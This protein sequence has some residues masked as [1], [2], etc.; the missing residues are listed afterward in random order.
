MNHSLMKKI[1]L[2]ALL[3]FVLGLIGSTI[4]GFTMYQNF[5]G[6]DNELVLRKSVEY[7]DVD[8]LK[9]DL[10]LGVGQVFVSGG[11]EQLMEGHFVYSERAGDPKLSYQQ[12]NGTGHVKLA[13][14][15]RTMP[16]SFFNFGEFK[17][18]WQVKLNKELPMNLSISTGVGEAELDLRGV[19]L[20]YL[21]IET[22]VGKTMID[23]SG[24]WQESFRMELETGV[25]QTVL[26]LPEEVGVKVKAEL[27]LGSFSIDNFVR[28]GD[29]YVNLAY[30][31][32]DVI[33]ELSL[34]MGIGD[35]TITT[36]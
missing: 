32:A 22:G 26:Y 6:N 19:H 2:I 13:Q 12:K 23:L 4:F 8:L 36:K 31:Q 9:V 10:R 34:Q 3:V 14:K 20:Q 16:F 17:N 18:D 15:N 25:G 28:K 27:G 1:A 11:T 30:D 21:D 5:T 7:E 29:E 33:I 24:D 35:L